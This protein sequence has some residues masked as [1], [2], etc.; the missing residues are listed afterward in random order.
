M[1]TSGGS[2]ECVSWAD[3]A[4]DE[5][6]PGITRQTVHGDRQTMIRYLYEPGSVFPAHAH[7]EEQI[8]VVV[9]GRIAFQIDRQWRELG[10]GQVAIIPANMPH[11]ARVVGSETVETFNALS[12]RR[13]T[14][15]V[16]NDGGNKESG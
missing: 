10:P 9:R 5:V 6:L 14:A 16:I 13:T 2:P 11:G 15:P 3:I 4:A 12:P 7:P 8:T 1:S